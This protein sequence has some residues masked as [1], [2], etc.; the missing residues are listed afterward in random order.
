[1]LAEALIKIRERFTPKQGTKTYVPGNTAWNLELVEELV[2]AR[3]YF[4]ARTVVEKCLADHPNSER[5]IHKAARV[6]SLQGDRVGAGRLYF[7]LGEKMESEGQFAVAADYFQRAL[8]VPALAH[9]VFRKLASLARRAGNTKLAAEHLEELFRRHER[10]GDYRQALFVISEIIDLTGPTPELISQMADLLLKAGDRPGA[11][12]EAYRAAGMNLAKSRPRE[13]WWLLDRVVSLAP[14]WTEP[15]ITR[16]EVLISLGENATALSALSD[17]ANSLDQPM[18]A[19]FIILLLPKGGE[20]LAEFILYAHDAGWLADW[21]LSD[22]ASGFIQNGQLEYAQ[23][24][25]VKAVSGLFLEIR[26]ITG[27]LRVLEQID[28]TRGLDLSGA[29]T[30]A[31]LALFTQDIDRVMRAMERLITIAREA[32]NQPLVDYA[33]IALDK[34]FNPFAYQAGGVW[35]GAIEFDEMDDEGGQFVLGV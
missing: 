34:M 12:R 19:E 14:G 6:R 5:V 7:S 35:D 23:R 13:A 24:L 2:Q 28:E 21:R 27:S 11:A 26:T 4:G 16:L 31:R 17:V 15:K 30:R 20:R 22:F 32:G 9:S 33:E 25:A 3:E 10:N 8:T 18:L 29:E 1:M